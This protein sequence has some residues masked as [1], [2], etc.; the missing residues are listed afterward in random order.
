MTYVFLAI[1]R[2]PA[3]V[4]PEATPTT[5]PTEKQEVKAPRVRKLTRQYSL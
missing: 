4:R 3:P 2:S 1:F 5:V